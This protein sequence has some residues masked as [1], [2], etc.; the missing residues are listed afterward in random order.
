MAYGPSLENPQG[1]FLSPRNG[2][3]MTNGPLTDAELGKSPA[4][5][6]RKRARESSKIHKRNLKPFVEYSLRLSLSR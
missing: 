2:A 4:E 3:C 1:G 6:G 5:I